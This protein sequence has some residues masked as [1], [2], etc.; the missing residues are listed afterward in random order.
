[1]DVTITF[2]VL[3]SHVTYTIAV[4]KKINQANQSTKAYLLGKESLSVIG[5]C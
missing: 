5:S 4:A 3:C 2:G 1:M